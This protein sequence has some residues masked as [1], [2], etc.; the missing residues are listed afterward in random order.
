MIRSIIISLTFIILPY[1][2]FAQSSEKK[3]GSITGTV[4]D[5]QTLEPLIGVN[6]LIEKTLTG[7]AS[8]LDGN[9]NIENLQPGIYSLLVRYIGYE[10]RTLPDIVV[11]SNRQQILEIKLNPSAVQGEE[12]TV[13]S[14]YFSETS[15]DGIGKVSF[16]PE[17][18]RRS[19]GAAQELARVLNAL[20]SVASKGETSQDMLV[21]GGS[22]TENGYY[23]DNIP[24]PEVRHFRT[25]S[26][27]SNGPIGLVNTELVSDI[28][29]AAGGFSSKFGNH[30]SSVSDISYR[31][32]NSQRL[33][34]DIGANLAGFVFNL[35]GPLSEK[36][37]FLVSARRSYLDL[38]ANAINAGGAPSFA[39]AQAKLTFQ[40]NTKNKISFLNIYG[41]SLFENDIEEALDEG[42]ADA[43]SNQNNQNTTGLNWKH[44]W[45]N[46]FTN[47]SI[48]Y[49]FREQEQLQTDVFT[50]SPSI[51]FDSRETMAVLRSTSYFRLN[52]TNSF[53]FGIE[54]RAE[55][56]E[57]DY[58]IAAETN[59]S[60]EN[61]PDFTR[62]DDVNGSLSSAFASYTIQPTYK[63]SA[64]FGLRSSYN[65]Y[66]EDLNLSPRFKAKYQ[67]TDRLGLNFASGIYYQAVPRYLISQNAA[68]ADLKST[69]STQFV[70]GMDYLLT[71]DT[72]LTIELYDKEYRNAPILPANNSVGDRNYV[73]DSFQQFY[74]VLEDNGEAYARG[75]EVL[76]QKKLAVDFYGMIS[77]SYFR[78]RHKDFTGTWQDRNFD[79]RYLFSVIG[80]YRPNDLWEISVRWSILG[81]RAYTPV[82]AVASADQNTEILE[83]S[84]FN[85]ERYPA[86]HSLFTR[87]DR[88]FFLKR[89][90]MVIFLEVWNLY[91]QQNVETD[92][93][94]INT[95]EVDRAT[96]FNLLPVSGFK[97][98]F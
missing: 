54:V 1:S 70:L 42:F 51:D 59:Q 13:T 97:F 93:W 25:Q 18:I 15:T 17:E 11:G 56:N 96:Q 80:G 85:E 94:N 44:L 84:R 95:Q 30:L 81:G 78:T 53:E 43:V 72:K 21:R 3:S 31:D 79:N 92:F 60:G 40:P 19:P 49:S 7:T 8:D 98:E 46:G 58:F 28:E 35:D 12:I 52:P 50:E 68:L 22:P 20:P 9:F 26:G 5:A 4:V 71:D 73:L 47:T 32:G 38:I 33:R 10:T 24:L 66:N 45:G 41:T 89:T 57:Y 48:S 61:Q 77:G 23:I 87:V 75:V 36:T 64:T 14:G 62:D 39:D 82:D 16:T 86:Y 83:T 6:L 90:N 76:I 69:R 37:T 27:Q 55:Q 91:N 34:G 63:L 65:S 29:F 2:L 67:A 88:R 74:S